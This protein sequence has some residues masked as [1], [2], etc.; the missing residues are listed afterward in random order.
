MNFASEM[1]LNFAG[2]ADDRNKIKK[3]P[4]AQFS[5]GEREGRNL[6]PPV[7]DAGE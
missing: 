1:L 4:E 2:K 5:L 7:A 6:P 3:N